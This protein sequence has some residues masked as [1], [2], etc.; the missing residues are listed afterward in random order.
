MTYT[1]TNSAAFA[2]SNIDS[3][4]CEGTMSRGNI[5]IIFADGG[6]QEFDGEFGPNDFVGF[7]ITLSH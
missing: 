2:Q 1:I 5:E 7:G 3:F 4:D 6:H